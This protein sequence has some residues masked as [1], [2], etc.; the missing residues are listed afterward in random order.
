MDNIAKLYDIQHF[1]S[2]REHLGFIH[3][4]LPH[5]EFLYPVA[6]QVEGGVCSPNPIQ[7]QLKAADI[8]P[9]STLLPGG[10]NQGVCLRQI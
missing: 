10:S 9:V 2:N 1:E 5:S 3:S 6:E 4:V 7:R 8:C